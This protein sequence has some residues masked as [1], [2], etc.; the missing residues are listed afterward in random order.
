MSVAE[1][2]RLGRPDATDAEVADAIDIAAAR[3]VYHLPSGLDTRI[4][5]QGV[6]LSGAQ[7]QRLCLARAIVA[8]PK[9][10]VIDDTL[11]GL[12]VSPEALRLAL[13]GAT[14]IVVAHRLSTVLLADRVVLLEP[15][16][17]VGATITHVGTHEELFARVERYRQLLAAD[18]EIGDLATYFTI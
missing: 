8:A 13:S 1:N 15:D 7:R 14:G 17:S 16:D 9:L 2:V 5:Q 18:H 12:D 3:F 6:R 11:A 10:L 4:G